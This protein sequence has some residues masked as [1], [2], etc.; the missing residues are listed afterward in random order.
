M[1][2][3][4]HDATPR[5]GAWR[6]LRKILLTLLF[7]AAVGGLIWS[8]L[9]KGVYP[10]DLS[11]I[12]AGRPAVVLAQDP[13]FVGGMEVMQLLNAVRGDYADRV[14][15]L[16]APLAMADAREFAR[17]HDAVDGTVL[18]FDGAG[19]LVQSLRLPRSTDELRQALA[20]LAP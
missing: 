8:Q 18:L 9:P 10:T 12:G 19:R 1:T 15:F 17:R 3:S 11:R 5:S 14:D 4:R 16:V 7:V 13:S 20:Q 2:A 6:R